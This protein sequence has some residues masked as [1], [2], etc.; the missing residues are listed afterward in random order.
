MGGLANEVDVAWCAGFYEGEGS[1]F[2][3]VGTYK[4]SGRPRINLCLSVPQVYIEPLEKFQAVFP[5][6]TIYY[7]DRTGNAQ[8]IYTLVYN[9]ENAKRVMEVLLPLL[10]ERRKEQY[11][12]QLE[13]LD[14]AY[15]LRASIPKKRPDRQTHCKRGHEFTPENTY[16]PKAN[17]KQVCKTCRRDLERMRRRGL[18]TVN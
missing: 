4:E 15:E 8:G 18:S 17:G 14:A 3:N 12:A 11:N 7:R 16:I 9:N 13:K 6:G 5:G 1:I 10:S 2:A